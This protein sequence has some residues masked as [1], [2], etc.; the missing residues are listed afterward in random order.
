MVENDEFDYADAKVLIHA[1]PS[2]KIKALAAVIRE[3]K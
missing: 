3:A 1:D 2:Q